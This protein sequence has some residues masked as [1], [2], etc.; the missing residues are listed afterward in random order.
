MKLEKFGRERMWCVGTYTWGK[1]KKEFLSF[2]KL[3]PI[4]LLNLKMGRQV[5]FLAAFGRRGE[6]LSWLK[7]VGEVVAVVKGRPETRLS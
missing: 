2:R 6:L 7:S 4:G 1:R 5:C 3:Q